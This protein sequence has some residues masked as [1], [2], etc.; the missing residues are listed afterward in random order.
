MPQPFTDTGDF[1]QAVIKYSEL[2]GSG[3]SYGKE[4]GPTSSPG[5]WPGPP[6]SE[7]GL[8]GGDSSACSPGMRCAPAQA[9]CPGSE[10]GWCSAGGAEPAALSPPGDKSLPAASGD[11]CR[12]EFCAGSGEIWMEKDGKHLFFFSQPGLPAC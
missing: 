8:S 11:V 6:H 10:Q 9:P 4:G 7:V 3:G 2:P 1:Q 5:L 12:D